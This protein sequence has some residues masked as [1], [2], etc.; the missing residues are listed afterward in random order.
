[1]KEWSTALP[2]W[3]RRI[4][5]RESLVPC[6]P[7]F[8][9][10]AAAAMEVFR[11]LQIVD[12]P[13]SPS[14]GDSCLPWVTG[15]AEGIFGA[16]D[17]EI[18]RRLIRE[19]FLLVSKKNTKSTIAAAIM[20]T[21]L[22]RNWRTSAEFLI[23]APTIE[24]AQNSFKPASDMVA[25][26]P[27]LSALL[28][29]QPNVRTITHRNTGAILKVVAADNDTVSGKKATGVLVDEL[30]LFGKR[31]NAENM[32]REATGGLV[33]RP[34][35]FVIYLSTQSD[36]PPAGVFRQKLQYF[37]GVRDGRIIDPRSMG[38]LYEFP[39]AMVESG[40]HLDI[41][42]AYITNPN[43]GVS[44]DREWLADELQK[45]K[46][47]GTSSLIG[48]ASK[49]LNVEIGL[50]LGSDNWVGA[51]YWERQ[52][53]TALTFDEILRRCDVVVA[54]VDGGGLDDLLALALL[55]RDRETKEWLHWCHA[56][57]HQSV[58]ER[59]KSEVSVLQDYEK[60]GDL[61]IIKTLGED[62]EQLAD[63]V[64]KVEDFGLLASVGLDPMG[65]GA[66]V[67]ALAA[68]GID[69][70]GTGPSRVEG[71]AQGYR[72]T[73][74]I[75]TAERKLADGSLKH[76]AQPLM[77]YAV[78]NAKVEPKGNAIT[79]TKQ[80]AGRAKIDPLMATFNAVALMAMNPEPAGSVYTADR[81]LVFFG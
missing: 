6:A 7:L 50:G 29:V 78:G 48:F 80:V 41:E 54:G 58:L 66:V 9:D 45:A 73:T 20:L 55:G 17:H 14:I 64:K 26:D 36:A 32:L 12:A 63:Y 61:T 30:W 72:L 44:V 77:T 42:N 67:D 11:S 49:H 70:N 71:I 5:A 69:N 65:I 34:E 3:E 8:P 52:G 25:A 60:G 68:R 53:D 75:W 43:L 62:I 2:D 22:I 57:A 13:G 4:V 46:D 31:A 47:A 18:G 81:G 59:R 19:F 28:H 10:E 16:Y 35:G 51:E 27:E 76:G 37:R 40:A 39:P 23:V 21:A 79:I 56:W 74:A 24:V 38:V 1:M 33:S 15:F